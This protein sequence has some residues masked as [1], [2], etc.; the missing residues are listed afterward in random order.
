MPL[1]DEELSRLVR[2]INSLGGEA[3][4][5]PVPRDRAGRIRLDRLLARAVETGASDLLL[6]PG[7]PPTGRVDGR[8]IAVDPQVLDA[9]TVRSLLQ[10][11]LD[12]QRAQLLERDQAADFCFDRPSI[13]RFRCNAHHQRGSLAAAIRVFPDRIPTL[14]ELGLPASLERFAA[15]ERGLVLV[16]GPAGCGKSTT[17]ASLVDRINRTRNAHVVSIE[18]PIEYLHAH[19]TSVIEQLEVGRDTPSFHGAIRSVLRQDPDV[20][21]V[22]EMRDLETISMVL[23]AAETGHLVFSTL[24]TGSAAQTLDRITDAFPEDRRAQV[25]AQLSLCLAGIVVQY[26]LPRREGRGRVPAVEVLVAT[27]GIRNLIRQG[28]N[29]QIPAQMT[30]A[31]GAGSVGLDESLARLVRSGAVSLEEARRRA[32][33]P[34]EFDGFLA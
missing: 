10:E 8:L 31:R 21:L 19:G 6:V 1:F 30:L 25:R 34:E 2:E 27:D 18:D 11:V 17:L 4:L 16:C 3:A 28:L 26:L 12:E 13:G 9:R 24:H 22:G 29:H 7:V 14:A 23:T 5:P 20:I 15:L 33:H 32:I